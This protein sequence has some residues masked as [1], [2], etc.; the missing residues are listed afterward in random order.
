MT[1]ASKI[2][3]TVVTIIVAA[4]LTGVVREIAPHAGWI[5]VVI[6]AGGFGL[7]LW[8]WT[9]GNSSGEKEGGN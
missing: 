4:M 3:I 2:T 7:I 6:G 8:I 5:R 9:R 1:R